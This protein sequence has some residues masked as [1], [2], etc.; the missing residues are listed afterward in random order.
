MVGLGGLEPPASPLS[1]VRS[2]QLSYRPE[3]FAPLFCLPFVVF[4]CLFAHI[5]THDSSLTRFD[6]SIKQKILA[7]KSLRLLFNKTQKLY[8]LLYL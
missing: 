7:K 1:G 6:A 3:F 4:A 5:L 8:V 2:N